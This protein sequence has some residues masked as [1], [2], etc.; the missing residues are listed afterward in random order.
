MNKVLRGVCKDH[1]LPRDYD[2]FYN[3]PSHTKTFWKNIRLAM[4]NRWLTKT[5]IAIPLWGL[6]VSTPV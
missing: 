3:Q 2:F 4:I 6:C 5:N 1:R